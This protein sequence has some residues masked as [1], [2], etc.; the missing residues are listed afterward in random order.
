[1]SGILTTP[2]RMKMREKHTQVS[3]SHRP[4]CCYMF[5]SQERNLQKVTERTTRSTVA[6]V[7]RLSIFWIWHL[8]YRFKN[9]SENESEMKIQC[10]FSNNKNMILN[11]S[12]GIIGFSWAYNRLITQ[13]IKHKHHLLQLLMATWV[14]GLQKVRRWD[15]DQGIN[16]RCSSQTCC[17]CEA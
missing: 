12:T 11:V 4:G 7:I 14:Q 2:S 13:Q 1:M 9:F 3:R 10:C 5:Q 8:S 17:V 15:P 6:S 16:E